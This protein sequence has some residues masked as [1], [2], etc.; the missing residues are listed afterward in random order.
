M[1]VE[2]RVLVLV[3]ADQQEVKVAPP[4]PHLEQQ[5]LALVLVATLVAAAL[6]S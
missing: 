4:Q 3:E 5:I 1:L 6:A 2:V